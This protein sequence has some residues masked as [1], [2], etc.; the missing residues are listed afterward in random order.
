MTETHVWDR[1]TR[2]QAQTTTNTD[3]TI[4]GNL[5]LSGERGRVIV[6][7]PLSKVRNAIVKIP[8]PV[9]NVQVFSVTKNGKKSPPILSQ[10]TA[11]LSVP[12]TIAPYYDF[13]VTFEETFSPLSE[14]EFIIAPYIGGCG[15]GDYS[16]KNTYV[17]HDEIYRLNP[18]PLSTEQEVVESFYLS[19]K[20]SKHIVLRNAP[21]LFP[22][23]L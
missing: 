10:V 11:A 5:L 19:K 13:E 22:H 15:G 7:N 2:E 9:C 14:M 16:K 4:L 6:Y 17:E 23:Q 1:V 12:S 18:K 3:P 8:V 20:V 21:E